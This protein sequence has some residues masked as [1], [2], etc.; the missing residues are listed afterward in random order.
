MRSPEATPYIIRREC[1]QH[2]SV[3]VAAIKSAKELEG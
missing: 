2:D 1:I 3:F